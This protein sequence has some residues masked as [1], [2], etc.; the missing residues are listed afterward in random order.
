MSRFREDVHSCKMNNKRVEENRNDVSLFIPL[1]THFRAETDLQ[2]TYYVTEFSTLVKA[3]LAPL[4]HCSKMAK[5]HTCVFGE[6][7]WK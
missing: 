3:R 2:K 4:H 7:A 6:D 5:K 1:F